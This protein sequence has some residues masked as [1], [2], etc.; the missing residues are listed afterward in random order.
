MVEP[1]G[2]F[3]VR[4]RCDDDDEW[5]DVAAY[6]PWDAARIYALRRA[7]EDV[8]DSIYNREVLVR[9][10]EVELLIYRCEPSVEV[11]LQKQLRGA[12]ANDS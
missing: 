8:G 5:Q 11:F 10:S 6:S 2:H 12:D 9:V 3:L 1:K 7:T 4:L